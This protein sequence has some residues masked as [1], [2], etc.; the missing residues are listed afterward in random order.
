M[1]RLA[2]PAALALLLA[3]CA[4]P[5][6][7]PIRVTGRPHPLIGA[8]PS[9]AAP[10]AAPPIVPGQVLH[11]V[12]VD[13]SYN[14]A[15]AG[16]STLWAPPTRVELVQFYAYTSNQS[17]A[18]WF[19]KTGQIRPT[20]QAAVVAWVQP[21]GQR[22]FLGLYERGQDVGGGHAVFPLHGMVVD[23]A[24]GESI[25]FAWWCFGRPDQVGVILSVTYREA[26]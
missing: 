25:F 6:G 18:E 24:A 26:P 14:C 22:K 7:T 4:G 11:V 1:R 13:L 9:A 12:T 16:G 21:G 3:G 23:P 8:R 5:Y 20:T 2:A 17:D 19:L 15:P 10:A